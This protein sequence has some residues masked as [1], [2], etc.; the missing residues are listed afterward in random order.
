MN[1]SNPQK[2]PRKANA[3]KAATPPPAE[4]GLNVQLPV[5]LHKKLKIRAIHDD[6]TLKDVVVSAL[7]TYL[8]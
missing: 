1:Q 6:R 5:G 2:R 8:R 4:V 3:K 7:E